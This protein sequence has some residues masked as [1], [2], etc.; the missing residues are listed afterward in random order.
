MR[1]LMSWK[2]YNESIVTNT[3]QYLVTIPEEAAVHIDK[4]LDN[5]GDVLYIDQLDGLTFKMDDLDAFNFIK[6]LVSD[7]GVS[8]ED[9]Q[10]D[11]EIYVESVSRVNEEMYDFVRDMK[12]MYGTGNDVMDIVRDLG[13]RLSKSEYAAL[14][15]AGVIRSKGGFGRSRRFR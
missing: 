7:F 6:I 5:V 8:E 10:V 13:R 15:Q 1:K 3:N 9:I 12:M 2:K 4:I 14:A 11:S